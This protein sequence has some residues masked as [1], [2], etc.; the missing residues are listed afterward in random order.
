MII[1]LKV[2]AVLFSSVL[3]LGYAWFDR[4][5]LSFIEKVFMLSSAYGL[6]ITGVIPFSFLKLKRVRVVFSTVLLI[7]IGQSIHRIFEAANAPVSANTT[8]V[9]LNL[10]ILGLLSTGIYLALNK[11]IEG[12]KGDGG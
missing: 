7:G 3:F 11:K 12:E 5:Y 2:I 8:A 6:L 10:I 1:L 9:L 4:E